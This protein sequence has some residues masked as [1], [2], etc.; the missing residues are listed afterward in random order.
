MRMGLLAEERRKWVG[1]ER[2]LEVQRS[3]W[4]GGLGV[5]EGMEGEVDGEVGVS[6]V[7]VGR[8][9]VVGG[10]GGGGVSSGMRTGGED[11]EGRETRRPVH[12]GVEDEVEEGRGGRERWVSRYRVR[13]RTAEERADSPFLRRSR[14]WRTGIGR[15]EGGKREKSND[16]MGR[17]VEAPSFGRVERKDGRMIELTF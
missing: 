5:E 11:S 17:L 1:T 9:L 4:S 15:E 14:V 10:G 13:E 16:E 7:D 12:L 8:S 6:A 3:S 2:M